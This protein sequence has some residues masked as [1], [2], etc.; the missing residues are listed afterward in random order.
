M[1]LEHGIFICGDRFTHRVTRSVQGNTK[2]DPFVPFRQIR[3][4]VFTDSGE[5]RAWYIY[6]WWQIYSPSHSVRTRKYEARSLRPFWTNKG[7]CFSQI[8]VKVEHGIFIC[9][10]KF[11]HRV[12]RSIQG[13][14]KQNPFVPF[15]QIRVIVFTDSGEATAWYIYLSW[16]I[17]PPSYSVCTRKYEARSL[18]PFETNK[19]NCFSQ[20]LVKLE[21]G[22]FIWGDKFTHRV[23]RSIQGNT[24]TDPFV[25]FRQIR[26]I[27][28][29]RFWWS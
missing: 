27:V 4:I 12:T 3:V 5:A 2:P 20:N 10:D 7:N 28:F 1:K 29:S 13:N 24:K 25:P 16:Q 6:L 19:G 21:H 9:G 18:C 15:R 26:V 22:I 11:T 14:T 23:T 8:L 17:Y